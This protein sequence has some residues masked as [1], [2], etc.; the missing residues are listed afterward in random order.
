MEENLIK[1]GLDY[2][3]KSNAIIAKDKT[4]MNIEDEQK[5]MLYYLSFGQ[6]NKKIGLTIKTLKWSNNQGKLKKHW[7]QHKE[8]I[9]SI[10]RLEHP[11][12]RPWAWW[13]FDAPE[14]LR[15]RL[16]GQG[17]ADHEVFS[18]A[19]E[20]FFGVHVSYIQDD[21]FKAYMSLGE[22]LPPYAQPF[23]P[24]NAPQWE[25]EAS[26]LQRHGLLTTDE[27]CKL[28]PVDFKPIRIQ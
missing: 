10:W 16:G 5:Q 7:R 21:D 14:T 20:I 17:T 24:D 28:S 3:K 4:Q 8:D 11:G 13:L 9:L 26:Y 18:K 1:T 27:E 6:F 22:T 19:E 2:L 15:H 12:S 23:D 25:S